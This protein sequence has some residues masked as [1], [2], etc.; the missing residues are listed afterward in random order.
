MA[1]PLYRQIADDLRRRIE[2]GELEEG[3]QVPTED[4][5][6]ESYRASRNTVRGALKELTTRGLVYTLHGKGT[7]VSQR[8]SPLVT[9][10]TSDPKTGS[11]GG[12]GL[13]YTAEVAA[14]GRSP[15][16]DDLRLEIRK[17]GLV[18]SRLLR[19]PENA[20]VIIRHQR[21]YVDALPWSL[22][23][24]YYSRSLSRLASRLLDTSDIEEGTVA[25]MAACGIQQAGYQDA[26]EWRGPNEG[27]TAFFDLPPDGHIQVAE[28]SRIAFDPN[29]NR[30]RLTVTV[31]RADRNRFVI[32]VGDVPISELYLT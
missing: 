2:S 6:M 25:Y 30:I 31:Y 28:I 8:V 7:F 29:K 16:V 20:E 18:V 14:S 26:I 15:S 27:E 17:A 10:L 22:Q 23:T 4:H 12:E 11:G 3:M 9:T 13:V 5:L 24:S 32:N 21:R 19:I 1:G